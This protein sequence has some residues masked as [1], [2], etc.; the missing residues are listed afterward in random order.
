MLLF[1]QQFGAELFEGNAFE[2]GAAFLGVITPAHLNESN[3]SVFAKNKGQTKLGVFGAELARHAT[4]SALRWRNEIILLAM[5]T[6]FH[7]ESLT[8][9]LTDDA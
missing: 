1:R 5:G 2:N 6:L 9:E 8:R 4:K 7:G 3:L